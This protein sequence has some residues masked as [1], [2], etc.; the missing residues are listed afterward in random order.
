VAVVVAFLHGARLII[1]WHNYGYTILGLGLGEGH[2]VVALASL[3]EAVFGRMGHDHFCVTNAMQADLAAHWGVKQ[4][5][6]LHD[7]PPP[8]FQP[9]PKG[10]QHDL[11]ERIAATREAFEGGECDDGGTVMT[12]SAGVLRSDRPALLVSSTSWTPD[13]DFSVL[14]AALQVCVVCV[15]VCVCVCVLCVCVCVCVVCV[16][17]CVCVCV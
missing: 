7:R 5:R 11:F 4:A 17:E 15:C 1:D 3:I 10:E 16:C 13:E 9:T 12:S 8:F 6:A 2:P 14:L